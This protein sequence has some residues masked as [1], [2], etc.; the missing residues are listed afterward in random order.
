[1]AGISLNVTSRDEIYSD[2]S[3]AKK[4][5][6]QI[7]LN[8]IEQYIKRAEGNT[9]TLEVPSSLVTS[10]GVSDVMMAVL[11]HQKEIVVQMVS[12]NPED[13][14]AFVIA[15]SIEAYGKQLEAINAWTE[16]GAAVI[17]PLL[18]DMAEVIFSDG[19]EGSEYEDLVQIMILDLM[20]QGDL[21]SGWQKEAGY[22]LESGG[23]GAHS[24]MSQVTAEELEVF[25]ADVY[26]Y[27]LTLPHDRLAYQVANQIDPEGFYAYQEQFAETYW[28]N[29]EGFIDGFNG[30]SDMGYEPVGESTRI[31]PFLKLVIIGAASSQGKLSAESYECLARAETVD[32]V[33]QILGL[34]ADQNMTEWINGNVDGADSWTGHGEDGVDGDGQV[35]W[36]FPGYGISF[37]YLESLFDDFP[38][39]ELTEE[40]IEE[41]NRIGDQVKMLQQTLLY[42]LKICRDEQMAIARNI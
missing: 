41:V 36:N 29:S 16:G 18:T 34:S 12:S 38:G 37:S 30:D 23:S 42:W 6:L 19:V 11:A 9:R 7:E 39:R 22:F 2:S 10:E 27:S 13:S 3:S 21:P 28:T 14:I 32:E 25:M 35:W 1:M 26:E 17:V 24:P 33:K 31:S 20:A 40:E 8:K 4:Y 15:A 5:P